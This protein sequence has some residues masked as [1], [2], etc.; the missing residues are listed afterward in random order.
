MVPVDDLGFGYPTFPQFQSMLREYEALIIQE[1]EV[2]AFQEQC[3]AR[4]DAA[5]EMS[6]CGHRHSD[7]ADVV[8]C[9][10]RFIDRRSESALELQKQQAEFFRR[11]THS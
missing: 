10:Y 11:E 8:K 3:I 5:N 7:I 1:R 6:N 9:G 2:E 4:R